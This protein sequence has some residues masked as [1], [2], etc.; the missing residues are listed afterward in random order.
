MVS[1]SVSSSRH[2]GRVGSFDEASGLGIVADA[3]GESHRFHCISIAD[4]TRTIA[5]GTHV[6]FVLAS[7]HGDVEAI[8]VVYADGDAQR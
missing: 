7:R 4:G 3:G 6:S 2:L 8:D 5:V 1:S